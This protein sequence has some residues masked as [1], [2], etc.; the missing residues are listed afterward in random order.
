MNQAM[1]NEKVFNEKVFSEKV[2]NGKEFSENAYVTLF[3]SSISKWFFAAATAGVTTIAL[4]AL[5]H[6]LIAAPKLEVPI[7]VDRPMPNIVL[8]ETII[9]DQNIAT[10]PPKPIAAE[11][12]PALPPLVAQQITSDEGGYAPVAPPKPTGGDKLAILPS[13]F[14]VA[15]MMVAPDYPARA[16]NKGI[17]GFVDV[18]FDVTKTGATSNIEVISAQPEKIFNKS[19]V[20]AIK[21]W[22]FTPYERDGEVVAFYGMSRRVVFNLEK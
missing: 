21:R 5:M 6:I 16:A 9:E 4:V 15:R 20:N 14:P 10:L 17:E 12:E 1:F 7:V 11:P 3:L 18:R 19:A 2:F 8:K 13:S 22:K